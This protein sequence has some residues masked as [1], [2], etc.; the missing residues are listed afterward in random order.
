MPLTLARFSILTAFC[1]FLLLIAGALV[2][3]LGSG[4]AVPDWPLSFGQ[5][6]P[7]ME[8]GVFYEHGHR[9]I[10]GT[11]GLMTLVLTAWLWASETRRWL[12]WL[13][14]FA[15]LA[16]V[17]QAALGGLT[18]LF[19]LPPQISIAHAILAQTFFC[20]TVSL[21]FFMNREAGSSTMAFRM[22]ASGILSVSMTALLFIQLTLGAALRHIGSSSYLVLHASVA[23]LAAALSFTL[24][25]RER[26]GD[27]FRPA[28]AVASL[29]LVQACLGALSVF[30]AFVPLDLSWAARTLVATSHVALGAVIL[31]SS[32]YIT[33]RSMAKA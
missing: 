29:I 21:A 11:V 1:T 19:K 28:L 22:D 26:G 7:R 30:P 18:V 10:A 33:L 13:G 32:L 23:G 9:M 4:L 16:V 27:L 15:A 25:F 17:A 12:C 3:S 6:F 14:T 24:L 5:F 2:T 8:G 20:L 31:A